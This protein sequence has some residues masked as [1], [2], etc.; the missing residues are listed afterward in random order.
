MPP[1]SDDRDEGSKD[2]N[3]LGDQE[4]AEHGQHLH[5]EEKCACANSEGVFRA[6]VHPDKGRHRVNRL[7]I[8]P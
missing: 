1:G 8:Y 3:E 5:E 2:A 7:R 4:I 6:D